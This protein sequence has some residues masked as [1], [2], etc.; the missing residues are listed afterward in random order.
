MSEP[1]TDT[2]AVDE[3]LPAPE[4]RVPLFDRPPATVLR[5]LA[6]LGMLMDE[7]SSVQQPCREVHLGN[8][9]THR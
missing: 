1:F 3:Q 8:R 9:C 2:Q 6:I 4:E 7:A 5:T